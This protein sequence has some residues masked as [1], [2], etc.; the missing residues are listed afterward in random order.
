MLN[1]S[2]FLKKKIAQ[3][4]FELP[5]YEVLLMM[6]KITICIHLAYYMS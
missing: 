1:T 5:E 4:L 6:K 2:N 3:Q